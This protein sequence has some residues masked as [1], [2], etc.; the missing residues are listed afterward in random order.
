LRR[1]IDALGL[2]D[3]VSLLGSRDDVADLMVAA[4]VLTMPSRRE[5]S[6]GALIEAMALELPAVVSD[7]AQTRDV[8]GVEGAWFVPSESSEALSV[9]VL[10]TLAD[11]VGAR[12]RAERAYR[13]FC[14]R[15]TIDAIAD[16]MAE[17]YERALQ[18]SSC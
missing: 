15:F 14:D 17:F 4:D 3:C 6:P 18:G 11:P 9:G 16:R 5:G 7:I 10:G 1:Q 13:T 8:V 2:A 12:L